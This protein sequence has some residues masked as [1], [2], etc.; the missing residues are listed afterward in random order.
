M[1]TPFYFQPIICSVP[2]SSFNSRH[3]YFENH[4]HEKNSNQ[5]FL[6]FYF[7]LI[8]DSMLFNNIKI[9]SCCYLCLFQILIKFYT[10]KFIKFRCSNIFSMFRYL[11]LTLPI[12]VVRTVLKSKP[13]VSSTLLSTSPVFVVRT[14]VVTKPLMSGILF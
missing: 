7:F 12:F 3:I 6:V 1:Y 10:R 14:I 5:T 11:F 4:N 13:L 8:F 2:L 9:S